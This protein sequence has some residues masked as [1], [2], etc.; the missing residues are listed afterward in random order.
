MNNLIAYLIGFIVRFTRRLIDRKSAGIT[1][2][3]G[4]DN[5]LIPIEEIMRDTEGSAIE[6]ERRIGNFE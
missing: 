1:T 5:D 4:R 6:I 3:S 2:W